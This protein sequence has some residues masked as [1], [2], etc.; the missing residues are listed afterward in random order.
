MDRSNIFSVANRTDC[1]NILE[2]E[3]KMDQEVTVGGKRAKVIDV[4]NFGHGD[5]RPPF[6]RKGCVVLQGIDFIGFVRVIPNEW[7]KMYTDEIH[8][9]EL[10]DEQE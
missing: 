6:N 9:K 10:D 5:I 3:Y 4:L 7:E 8:E 1:G 2:S